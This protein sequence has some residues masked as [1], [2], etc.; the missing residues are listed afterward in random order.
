MSEV[1]ANI[2]VHQSLVLRKNAGQ[3]NGANDNLV[4]L[5][6]NAVR[7]R[8]LKLCNSNATAISKIVFILLECNNYLHKKVVSVFDQIILQMHNIHR[9]KRLSNVPVLPIPKHTTCEF[10]KNK[11]KTITLTHTHQ[12]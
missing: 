11:A 6:G 8:R 12:E 4:R 3:L 9:N 10:L 5:V 2:K 7:Y 1:R